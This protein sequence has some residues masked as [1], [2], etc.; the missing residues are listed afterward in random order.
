[1]H[2]AYLK[3]KHPAFGTRGKGAVKAPYPHEMWGREGNTINEKKNEKENKNPFHAK[4]GDCGP[5]ILGALV[6]FLSLSLPPFPPHQQQGPTAVVVVASPP[7]CSVI[8][9]VCPSPWHFISL[10]S[11][12]LP[13]LHPVSSCSQ[14][15][16]W[17]LGHA[18]CPG[19]PGLHRHHP[20]VPIVIICPLVVSICVIPWFHQH[21]STSSAVSNSGVLV[22]VVIV[23]ASPSVPVPVCLSLSSA[24]IVLIHYP[25]CEQ[26]LTVVACGCAVL[27]LFHCK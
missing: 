24:V 9:I 6:L 11:F 20:L 19:L 15:W 4:C 10:I 27:T 26:V 21:G 14:Q 5:A 23:S 8:V 3:T 7:S 2:L 18:H 25:P 12:P 17:V 22:A 1:M 16:W 13:P